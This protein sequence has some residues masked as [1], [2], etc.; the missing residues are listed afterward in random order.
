M[1]GQIAFVAAAYGVTIVATLGLT[2]W[3]WVTMRAAE[4]RADAIR[5]P[6]ITRSK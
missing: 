3:S 4:A 6:E 1:S 5:W 2:M